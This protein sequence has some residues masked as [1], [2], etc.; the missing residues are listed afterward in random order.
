MRAG[1]RGVALEDLL[2]DLHGF[3]RILALGHLR[4]GDERLQTGATDD[5]LEETGAA[6]GLLDLRRPQVL[7]AFQEARLALERLCE[8]G[9]CVVEILPLE[10]LRA[11]NIQVADVPGHLVRR[12]VWHGANVSVG[13]QKIHSKTDSRRKPSAPHFPRRSGQTNRL[14]PHPGPLPI[15]WGEGEPLAVSPRSW[16]RKSSKGQE[17]AIAES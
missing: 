4:F 2:G 17:P 14:T 12:F 15:G 1:V 13:V 5:L 16:P 11:P 6:A 10:R 3:E 9:D 8:E 7:A